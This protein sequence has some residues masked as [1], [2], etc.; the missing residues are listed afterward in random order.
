MPKLTERKRRTFLECLETTGNVSRAAEA[1]ALP[2]QSFYKRR[3]SDPQFAAQWDEAVEIGVASLEDEARR[4]A[5]E[6]V[7]KPVFYQGAECGAVREFSDTLLIFL[8]K[9]HRPEKYRERREITG[10]DGAPLIPDEMSLTEQARR[11]AYL[12]TVG[13][14]QSGGT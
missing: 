7:L 13:S 1:A 14:K 3:R 8:L 5:Q 10:A 12:L 4:R 2:R 6:G 9:A 11:V